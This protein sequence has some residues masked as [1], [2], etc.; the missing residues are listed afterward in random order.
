MREKLAIRVVNILNY[1]TANDIK[2]LL[3]IEYLIEKNEVL[4]EIKYSGDKKDIIQTENKIS[5]DIIKNIA[6]ETKYENI[7]E[8]VY[9]NKVIVKLTS[10]K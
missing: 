4:V 8:D 3:N 7:N 6:S 1:D 10:K 2:I 5:K 9:T